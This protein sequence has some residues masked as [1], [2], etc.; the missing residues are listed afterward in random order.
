MKIVGLTGGIGSGKS[1]IA[2]WFSETGIPVYNSDNEAKKLMNESS[3]IRRKLIDLFGED[4]YLN[5]E[6]NRKFIS[7]KVFENKDLLEQ[8]NQI[9]HPEVF[10]DFK[11]WIQSQNAPFIVKE[12]AILFES[13][14]YNDCDY[15]ISVIA[16]EETRIQ[17]VMERDGVSSEQVLSRIQNQWTDELRIVNSDFIIKNN[18]GLEELKEEFEEVYNKLLKKVNAS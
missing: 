14:S 8:L 7:S 6:L 12:A 3:E 13:G 17:R 4:A 10:K 5:E 9:V 18:D 1:T 15:I 11:N 2:K 16:N